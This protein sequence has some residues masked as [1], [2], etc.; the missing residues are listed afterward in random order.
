MEQTDSQFRLTEQRSAFAAAGTV[1]AGGVVFDFL[2]NILW[3]FVFG[4]LQ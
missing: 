3:D 4:P 2:N 1:V